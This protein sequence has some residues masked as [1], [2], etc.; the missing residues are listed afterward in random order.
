MPSLLALHAPLL[1]LP[2]FWDEAGY[3]V[4]AARDLLLTRKPD[5][6][7]HAF[8]CPSAAGDGI[9]GAVVEDA[10]YAP[11]VTRIAMLLAASFSLLGLFRLAETRCQH[12]KSQSRPRSCTAL[13]PVFFAQ[14]SLAHLDLAAAGLTFWG[15]YAYVERPSLAD[16]ALVLARGAEPRRRQSWRRWRFRLGIAVALACT[17]DTRER[18]DVLLCEQPANSLWL[19]V[20]LLPLCCLVRLP[21]FADRVRFRQSGIFSLQRRR[22]RFIPCGSCW[23]C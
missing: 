20:P 11:L 19:L 15:L 3:Y 1:R 18:Q 12:A 9:S 6:A 8:Q 16:G 2:Y 4:P 22:P 7:L 5:S 14:S 23:L 10:G 13:Y 17:G 21:L